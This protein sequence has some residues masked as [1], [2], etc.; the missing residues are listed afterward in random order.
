M[1]VRPIRVEVGLWPPACR[2]WQRT[3]PM[4]HFVP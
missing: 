2:P 3:K 4:P 1:L